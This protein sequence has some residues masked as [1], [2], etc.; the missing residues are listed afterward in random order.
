[1]D[2]SQE[3]IQEIRQTPGEWLYHY[4]TME[5]AL[6][7]ILPTQE[8]RLSPFSRM[9]DPREY[10]K[11]LPDALGFY[12]GADAL[13]P[14]YET[15]AERANR[16]RDEFKLLS[17]TLDGEDPVEGDYGRGF[18]RSRLWDAYAARNSG[19]C[20]VLRKDDAVNTILPQLEAAGRTEHRRVRYE[21]GPIDTNVMFSFE[22]IFAG[23]VEAIADR[24]AEQHLDR[25]FLTKNTEW[26]SE[27]EYRFV[28]RSPAEY[29][30]VKISSALVAVCRGPESAKGS[31]HAL[32]YFTNE[33]G[34][35][36]GL[37]QWDH[38]RPMLLGRP[39]E[40]S[41]NVSTAPKELR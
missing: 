31:E 21:N 39:L 18:A 41:S 12:E 2:R 38:N 5:T 7:H 37:V 3:L 32:R 15:A 33:L 13:L 27:R 9:R 29:E 28:V 20:L 8:L 30:Y 17:F 40:P 14:H 10:K 16:L 24:L 4:T 36:L 25:L 1:V 23:D 19:V 22:E 26:E 35:A 34:I 6:V 11:W